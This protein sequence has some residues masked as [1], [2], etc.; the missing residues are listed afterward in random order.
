MLAL[1]TPPTH[2]QTHTHTHAHIHKHIHTHTHTCTHTAHTPTH[3]HTAHTP[4]PK[5][6]PLLPLLSLGQAALVNSGFND[7]FVIHPGMLTD[8]KVHFSLTQVRVGVKVRCR[9]NGKLI[10]VVGVS[11]VPLISC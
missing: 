8:T 3:A 2:A 5:A 10:F 1:D 7:R 9:V 11:P 6:G 4:T